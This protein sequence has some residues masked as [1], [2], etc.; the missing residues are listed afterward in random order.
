MRTAQRG[1]TLIELILVIALLAMMSV[2]S[3]Y[4]KQTEFE[5][6]RA[7]SVGAMLFQFNNAVRDALAQNNPGSS[8]T[9]QGSSWLKSSACGGLRAPGQEF[10]PCDFPLATVAN[11][12]PFGNLSL[13]TSILV[14]STSPTHKFT[15]TTTTSPFQLQESGAMKTRSDLSGIA[16]LTAASAVGVQ[17]QP[18]NGGIPAS[19]ATDA[20]YASDS[21]T[22]VITFTSSNAGGNDIWLKADGSNNMHKSLRFDGAA[23]GD[24]QIL[25]AS[26]IQNIAGQALVLGSG[27]GFSP[28]TGSAVVIGS[29]AEILGEFRNRRNLQ[30]DGNTI[31]AGQLGVAGSVNVG[32]SVT[33][34]GNI[35]ASTSAYAQLFLDANDP[36]YYFDPNGA[37]HINVLY[38]RVI[39]DKDNPSYYINPNN[40]SRLNQAITNTTYASLFYDLNNTGYYLQP[41]AG[42]RLSGI[43]SDAIYNYG[44][45]TVGEYVQLNGV[46]SSGAGC[47]PNGL[48]GRAVDGSALSCV[49]GAWAKM[50]GGAPTCQWYTIPGYAANNVTLWNCPSGLTKMGWD[51]TGKGWRR[52]ADGTVIGENDYALVNCCKF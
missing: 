28:V 23:F 18:L 52:A 37:S 46:A 9:Y 49:N 11:P 48:L 14:I 3:F 39:Y 50:G 10:L 17:V 22:G 36:N 45:M 1:V 30:V 38:A 29:N 24:R 40:S 44:R 34:N 35:I 8:I 5:Q 19:G 32:G 27:S 31:L 21:R 47:A 42:N 6:A 15:A 4:E 16:V 12:I 13:S 43:T 26:R 25:G 33:A 2:L 20:R 51:T 7:R 41:S